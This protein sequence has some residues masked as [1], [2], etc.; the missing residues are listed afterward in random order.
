MDCKQAMARLQTFL[1][2]E[3]SDEEVAEVRWHLDACP[4]CQNFFQFEDHLKMLIRVK[5]CPETAPGSL[6]ARI[7]KQFRQT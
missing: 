7:V 6:R 3:L 2:R 1:D 5:G 4:P